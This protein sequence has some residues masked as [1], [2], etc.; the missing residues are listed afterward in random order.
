MKRFVLFLIS[1]CALG[2][3]YSQEEIVFD[4][5]STIQSEIPV[6]ELS[7]E[8]PLLFENSFSI[9]E[10][11]SP[12]KYL[13]NQAVF[14]AY[15]KNLDFIKNLNYAKATFEAFSVNGYIASP[16]YLNGMVFNQATYRLGN[17]FSFGGNS[18]GVQSV[19][20]KPRMNSSINEMSTKG[21]SMFM[22]Y[23]ITK[24]IKV[25]TRVSVSG[26]QSPWEP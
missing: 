25:E 22:Q 7:L 26:G 24:N 2:F 19:F 21:A 14:P 20:D 16:F 23:K 13:F 17:K 4:S 6:K 18:F 5:I 11:N 3:A 12:D 10:M 8:K 9:G 15:N 1:F